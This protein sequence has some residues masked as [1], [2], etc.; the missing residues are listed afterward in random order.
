[1][2]ASGFQPLAFFLLNTVAIPQIQGSL[3]ATLSQ[4]GW[5]NT[6]YIISNVIVLPI[7]G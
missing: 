1:M 4:I 7:M 3:D 2:K 6:G 5:V